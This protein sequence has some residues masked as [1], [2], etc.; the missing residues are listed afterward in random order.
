MSAVS[1]EDCVARTI[2]DRVWL[3]TNGDGLQT[4]GASLATIVALFLPTF[5]VAR[6]ASR[7]SPACWCSCSTPATAASSQRLEPMSTGLFAVATWMI[8][9]LTAFESTAR[10]SSL[11]SKT[12]NERRKLIHRIHFIFD[13]DDDSVLPE[14]KYIVAIASSEL[15][16]RTPTRS[17]RDSTTSTPRHAGN[18][19]PLRPR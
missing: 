1:D 4:I 18:S 8:L 9:S 13:L 12:G 5:V 15:P 14:T 11:P 7:R 6:Q 10:I 16:T 3:D 19:N 17:L 2:G